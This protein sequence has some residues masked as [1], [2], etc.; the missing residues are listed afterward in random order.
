VSY[1]PQKKEEEK[2]YF[3]G[4]GIDRFADQKQ[5]L[6][7][8]VKDVRDLASQLKKKYGS[9]MIVDTLFDENFTQQ[10][11]LQW[12]KKLLNTSV[13]DKVILA[14]SGHGLLSKDYAYYLSTYNT[15]FENPEKKGISYEVLESLLDSIPVRK[16]LML[17]DACHS[18]EIDKDEVQQYR[19]S[20]LPGLTVG[21]K[22]LGVENTDSTKL[23][24][25]NSFELMK[26][27]FVDVGRATGTTIISAAGGMQLAQEKGDLKNGV[28][29][30]SIIEFINAHN[31]ATV[32]EL[33]SYVNKRVP[34]LTQGLQQPTTRTETKQID[35][36]VW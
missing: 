10:N 35:W 5:N 34:E 15:D 3:F 26:E 19:M 13:N 30:Y 12:K 16:K 20:K 1:V 27:L 24:L 18:G 8:S 22:G 36:N 9:R 2:L 17:I 21:S 7:Y 25:K 33:K 14:Y 6:S 11:L 32:S 23:G 29:T 31:S 28:F 4:A